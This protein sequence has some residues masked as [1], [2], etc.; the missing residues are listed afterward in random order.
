MSRNLGLGSRAA[1]LGASFLLE[2][3]LLSKFVDPSRPAAL[4]GIGAFAHSVQHFGFRFLVA[5]AAAAALFA[6]VRGGAELEAAEAGIRAAPIRGRWLALHAAL[7]ACLV[8][9]SYALYRSEVSPLPFPLIAASWVA[10]AAAA[11]CSAVAAMA[12]WRL[13]RRAAEALGSTWLYAAAVALLS[14]CAIRLSQML[15]V[16]AANLTFRLVHAS[17][18]SLTH[19]Q[20]ADAATRVLTTDRFSVE[21]TEVCSGL[22]GIGLI[23][24]FLAAWLILFRREYVFPRAL[25]LIPLGVLAMF[26]LNVVRIAVLVLIGDA[27]FPD[28]ASYGFH[29]QAGWISFIAVACGLFLLSRR[30]AWLYLP[31]RQPR[32]ATAPI[33]NPTAV[34]LMPLLAILAAAAVARALSG[35]FEYLYGLRVAA[36]AWFLL[37]YRSELAR[38][39]TWSWSWR[40]VAIGA[41]VFAVWMPAA[42]WLLPHQGMPAKLAALSVPGRTLWIVLRVLGSAALVPFAEELAYRGY[43][44]RRLCRAEF[45]TQPFGSVSWLALAISSIVFGAAHGPMWPAGIAAGLAYGALA[46]RRGLG[47]AVAAH[48]ASNVLVAAAVL[49]ANQWQLW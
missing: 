36:A 19:V 48:V 30:S 16:P 15:W 46:M 38:A 13:W 14:V 27:G 32:T 37:R 39:V 28:V 7:I 1:L 10:V 34:F 29:S 20:S 9:I 26:A 11:A 5:F 21:V 35:G 42:W 2:K 44:M 40:G 24:A 22:E 3:T 8:P 47:E 49:G 45:E 25:V 23:L 41:A 17:L 18:S 4:E 12:P 43:L 31:A 6:Y 33:H